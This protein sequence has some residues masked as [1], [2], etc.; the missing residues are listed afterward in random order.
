MTQQRLACRIIYKLLDV[1]AGRLLM[2]AP[3]VEV[4]EVVGR[5]AIL[6]SFEASVKKSI[7]ASRKVL[8][9]GCKVG[10][11]PPPSLQ[12]VCSLQAVCRLMVALVR[13]EHFLRSYHSDT[14][15]PERNRA[16][17]VGRTGR[18][19]SEVQPDGRLRGS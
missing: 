19:A 4:E 2:A 16:T 13:P 10:A 12:P 11:P 17:Q 18:P 9:A 14:G 8:V 6:A 7:S 15:W 5:V 3:V 1:L